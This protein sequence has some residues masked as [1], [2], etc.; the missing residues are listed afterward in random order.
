MLK[1]ISSDKGI[2]VVQ[3]HCDNCDSGW[4]SR[5]ILL[6]YGDR[7]IMG[8]DIYSNPFIYPGTLDLCRACVN[9]RLRDRIREALK[10]FEEKGNN[11]G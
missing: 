5:N 6:D 3:A 1:V 7:A 9:E 10:E 2:A 8:I 11:D 4:T